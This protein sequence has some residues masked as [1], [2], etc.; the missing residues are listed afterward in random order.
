MKYLKRITIF[1]FCTFAPFVSSQDI[2]EF[3]FLDD[4]TPSSSDYEKT[5]PHLTPPKTSIEKIKRTSPNKKIFLISNK[6]SSLSPGDFISLI[7]NKKLVARA[8]VAKTKRE[9]AGIKIIKIYEPK[10][11]KRFAPKRQVELLKGDDSYYLTQLALSKKK[12]Q[13][14][15]ESESLIKGTEDL[16]NETVILNE[17]KEFDDIDKKRK[18]K[19]DNFISLHLGRIAGVNTSGNPTEYTQLSVHWTYQLQDNIFVEASY[20]QNIVRDFPAVGLDTKLSNI[21]LK[22]KYSFIAPMNSILFPYVG[23]QILQASSPGEGV[24]S[25]GMT[26][27][28]IDAETR[29]MSSLRKKA[30]IFGASILKS[31]VP[32]WFTRIDVGTDFYSIG[33]GLEF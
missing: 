22:A 7:L 31:L 25:T 16:F 13:K 2:D 9:F 33:F 3:A 1:F 14:K 27:Q 26:Q 19:S 30:F 24:Y 6:S 15:K 28:D 32:G 18:V 5:L 17:E 10:L 20:G 12:K 11:W 21:V 23:Y 4:N 29:L 8:L